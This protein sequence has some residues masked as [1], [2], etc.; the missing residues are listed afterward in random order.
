MR[1]EVRIFLGPP[2]FAKASAGKPAGRVMAVRHSP[3]GDGGPFSD[4]TLNKF[5]VRL[6]QG[7]G[8][9]KKT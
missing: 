3:K 8:G 5:T 6:R 1:S 2:A 7:F 4:E 9:L